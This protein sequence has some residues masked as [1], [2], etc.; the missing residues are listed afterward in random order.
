MDDKDDGW[1]LTGKTNAPDGSLIAV[2]DPKSKDKDD[3]VNFDYGP[4]KNSKF[5]VN[6]SGNSVTDNHSVDTNESIPVSV[7]ALSN[8]KLKDSAEPF[9][10]PKEVLK[11]VQTAK[12]NAKLKVNNDIQT[13]A[14]KES[15]MTQEGV[16][17][18]LEDAQKAQEPQKNLSDE[19]NSAL[20]T[21]LKQRKKNR[22]ETVIH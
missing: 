8:V 4:V 16:T 17:K 3:V 1:T 5:K 12:S 2:Y 7:M 14:A 20:S 15:S 10:I 11:N 6:V 9:K 22:M 18:T 21:K 19:V 13:N